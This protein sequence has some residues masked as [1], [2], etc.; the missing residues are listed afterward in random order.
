M[1]PAPST[2][3][4]APS[5]IG[6]QRRQLPGPWSVSNANRT[7]ALYTMHKSERERHLHGLSAPLSRIKAPPRITAR[8]TGRTGTLADQ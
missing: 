7:E 5:P 6:L 2:A 3:P 1:S 8:R 4:D